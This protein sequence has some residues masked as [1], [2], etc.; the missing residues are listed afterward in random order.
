MVAAT[1]TTA[2]YFYRGNRA[3]HPLRRLANRL[4][5]PAATEPLVEGM[6]ALFFDNEINAYPNPASEMLTNEAAI[7]PGAFANVYA[8]LLFH[9][10][11]AIRRAALLRLSTGVPANLAVCQ[12]ELA[13]LESRL[14]VL[15][16]YPDLIGKPEWVVR[17]AEEASLL[18]RNAKE[19]EAVRQLFAVLRA[20][21]DPS[22]KGRQ[23]KE[24]LFNIETAVKAASAERKVR[25]STL[26]NI[27]SGKHVTGTLIRFR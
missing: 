19:Q 1:A 7:A 9:E 18:G 11:E 14:H 4:A 27:T 23:A 24:T 20:S 8:S 12:N 26:Y 25:R 16:S 5:P 13:R 6:L 10:D 2:F 21:T 22:L 3:T 15:T 17:R